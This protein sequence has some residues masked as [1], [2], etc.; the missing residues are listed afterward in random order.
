MTE[1]DFELGQL[2]DR[3]TRRDGTAPE[4]EQRTDSVASEHLT[5]VGNARRFALRHA[6]KVR[7]VDALGGWLAYDGRR[8]LR[9]ETGEV[10]RLFEET[11]KSMYQEASLAP[12]RDERE[13]L[14]QWA[15]KSESRS[16]IESAI[17]LARYQP[18]IAAR[19]DEFDQKPWLL[20]LLNGTIDLR[21]G[22]L[23]PH[24]REDLLT[25]LAPTSYDPAAQAPIF[26]AF[27]ERVFAG[28]AA[29][30]RFAQ[31]FV[32]H[33]LTGLTTEQVLLLLHGVGANGKTTFV[34]ILRRLLGSYA[35]AADFGTFLAHDRGAVRN[36]LARLVGARLVSAVEMSNGGRLDEAVVKQVTGGDMITARYLFHEHF[37]F[38]PEFKLVLVANH[39]PKIRGTD[40]AIWRRMKLVP[41]EV[42]IPPDERDP[43]LLQR[44]ITDELPGVLNWAL[45]GCR[46]WQA[47]GLGEP[48]EVTAATSE[49]RRE[50]DSL[51]PFLDEH[52]DLE[53]DACVTAAELYAAFKRWAEAA[54][55]RVVSQRTL[56]EWLRERG[57]TS[58]HTR[59][60]ARWHG[61]RV[62]RDGL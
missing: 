51:G 28:R 30:V 44:I 24:S 27:L 45:E 21:G 4:D 33:A 59:K 14:A 38:R 42:I 49:Y 2:I 19:A 62:T 10:Y 47:E 40:H 54:G 17:G 60:G 46:Q 52:C 29:L 32:G 25:K 56:G 18:Q 22:Q 20:N 13:H 50:Q 55:E 37:E 16:R 31:R 7:Y 3:Q 53:P 35:T 58:E 41:F 5:D 48:D 11:I 23:Q 26:L 9:D 39:K 15:R 36:D 34:E 12:T 8:W 6:N 43:L 1:R 61:L 57:F